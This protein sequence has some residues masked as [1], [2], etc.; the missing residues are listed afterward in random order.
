L[1]ADQVHVGS[2]PAA[3][4]KPMPPVRAAFA[5]DGVAKIHG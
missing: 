1:I 4:S 2:I 5:R 3:P